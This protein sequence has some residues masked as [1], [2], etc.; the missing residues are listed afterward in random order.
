MSF[1]AYL[2]NAEKQTGKTP[3][4]F[5]AE[6]KA[7]AATGTSRTRSAS[8]GSPTASRR[9]PGSRGVDPR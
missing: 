3:N 1:Q 8:T 7:K 5:I 2:D 6:A 4:D 9:P